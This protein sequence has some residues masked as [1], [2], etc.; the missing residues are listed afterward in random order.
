MTGFRDMSRIKKVWERSTQY[1]RRTNSQNLIGNTEQQAADVSVSTP[2]WRKK[3]TGIISGAVILLTVAGIIGYQQYTQY[4]ERNTFEFF[5]VYMNGQAVGTVETKESVEKLIASETTEIQKANPKV[6]MVLATG[7][8][9]YE[10]D[11]AFKAIPE[12]KATLAKLEGMFTSHAVGVEVKI[13][14]KVVGV[15]KDQETAD[16]ILKRVQSKFAPELAAAAAAKSA[17]SVKTLSFKEGDDLT[18]KID[19]DAKALKE[20][21]RLVT[22]VAFIEKVQ[23]AD[24]KTEPGKVADA[25]ALY[26][27]IVE[28]STKPTK[29]VVQ[30]G[31][32]VGCIAQKFDI[33]PQVIYENN[34][35]IKDDKITIGD[36]LDLTVLMPELTVRTIENLVELEKIAAPTEIVK[37]NKMRVGES[38]TI[39]EGVEGTQRLTYR[40]EK[41]NGYVMTEELVDKEILVE[42]IAEIIEKG[43]MVV[44]GEG[45][46]RFMIPVKNYRITSKYG[47]RWGRTHK[48]L[49]FIGSKTILAS[50]S[51]IIE[52]A[53]NK[54][55]TGKT[56]II[57]HQNGFKTLYGHMSSLKVSKGDK[58]EKGDGIGIMGNT[59]NSTGTHLHFEIHKKGAAQNP[60]KYL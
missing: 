14:G 34:P 22:E 46:G 11:K 15:V 54:E 50:D 52:F 53:G 10:S 24:I 37:N 39:K 5:N 49:D 3:S 60:L 51:G 23:V 17:P 27:R 40:I 35:W 25:D 59:G 1:F 56:I 30:E 41:Q 18:A 4:V 8:I 13:D 28:G 20:P 33:S 55:G 7:D 47:P 29:Y 6:N 44:L 31:D 48:G 32:C 2:L 19:P 57:N 58:V 45:T 12:T 43:T 21:G 16:S 9:T 26:K 36:E 38:K 42:P